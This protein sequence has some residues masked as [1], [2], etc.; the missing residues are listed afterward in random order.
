MMSVSYRDPQVMVLGNEYSYQNS[1]TYTQ[2]AHTSLRCIQWRPSWWIPTNH[3]SYT[4]ERKHSKWWVNMLDTFDRLGA[5]LQKGANKVT[6]PESLIRYCDLS[7]PRYKAISYKHDCQHNHQSWKVKRSFKI[8][9]SHVI[10]LQSIRSYSQEP[11]IM[12]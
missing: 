4:G 3:Q 8:Y 9:L 7:S 11:T 10:L 1:P 6:N 2:T 12:G 5:L